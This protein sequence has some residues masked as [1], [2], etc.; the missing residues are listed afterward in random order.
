[1][2]DDA[3]I[4]SSV[5]SANVACGYHGGDPSIMRKTVNL[6]ADGFVA[7]GA[8]VSYP[9]L[10]GFGRREMACSPDEIYD[11]CLYQIGAL[12]AFCGVRHVCLQHVKPHGALYNQAARQKR[13]ACAIASAVR[14]A[15][16]DIILVGL[17]N[18]EFE[19]AAMEA[20]VR[21]ASEGLADRAYLS[22]GSLMP[23][24]REGAVVRDASAAVDRALLMAKK[25]I[26]IA[27]DG[28]QINLR[29]DT[30]C[31]HGDTQGAVNMAVCVRKA[32][33]GAGVRVA[34]LRE[35]L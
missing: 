16:G 25:G 15:G 33:E 31:L 1:M 12:R 6:C 23:R 7:V 10:A 28:T 11:Y 24:S 32:L 34:A 5:S 13:L 29:P 19:A 22:D 30:I 18:S 21:F 4:L 8:H 35:A 20:G 27:D 14:D 9:D 2:G 26:V 3:S 17:A